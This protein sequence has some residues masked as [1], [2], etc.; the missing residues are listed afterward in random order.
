MSNLLTGDHVLA[1]LII[2]N[3]GEVV[4][5]PDSMRAL[6]FCVSVSHARFMADQFN[7][8]R[9][10]AMAVWA[11]TPA[12]QRREALQAR[13]EEHTSELQSLMRISYAGCCLKKKK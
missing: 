5:D 9:L 11:D 1:G 8:Y 6:G 3:V 13:S 10:P 12:E 2:S 7:A 4:P